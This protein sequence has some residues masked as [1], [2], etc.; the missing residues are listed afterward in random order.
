MFSGLVASLGKIVDYTPIEAGVRMRVA[1]PDLDFAELAIGDSIAH[2]GVC[3]TVTKIDA[4][5]PCYEVVIGAETLAL[6]CGFAVGETVNLEP[7]LALGDRIGGHLV[8]G[9]VDAVG[10]VRQRKTL[11]EQCTLTIDAP[12]DLLPL[13]AV[14]GSI[15]VHGVS[16]TV[17]RVDT[18]GFSVHLI[19]HTLQATN[20]SLLKRGQ[21]VN[22]EA[23]MLARY[24]ARWLSCGYGAIVPSHDKTNQP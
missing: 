13:I 8:Y 17:N 7:S 3:L 2:N 12:P 5:V 11:G 21:C 15:S 14:K 24:V 18:A 20:L 23:D 10:R 19:P 4:L 16:L 1:A 9:H 6:T 22:L